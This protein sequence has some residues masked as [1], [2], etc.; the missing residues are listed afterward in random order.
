MVHLLFP[1]RTVL[2]EVLVRKFPF[3][4]DSQGFSI[5]TA[6]VIFR[7]GRGERQEITAREVPKRVKVRMTWAW[8]ST[9]VQ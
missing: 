1:Y 3:S 9:I 5:E 2:Y 6:A 7:V 4:T 8:L